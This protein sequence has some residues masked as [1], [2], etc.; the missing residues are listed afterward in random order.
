MRE[1]EEWLAA[2][3]T[4]SFVKI[5]LGAAL[6]AALSWLTTSDIHPL[7]VAISAAVI[8]IIIN[9]IN[10]QDPRYGTVNWE[11]LDD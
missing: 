5:T 9:T 2:S 10:P 11:D 7:I 3:A 8:P 1:L 4:G 6:G